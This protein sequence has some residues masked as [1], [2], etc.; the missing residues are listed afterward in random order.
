[1]LYSSIYNIFALLGLNA[2]FTHSLNFKYRFQ[3]NLYTIVI[4]VITLIC[5]HY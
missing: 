2:P 4:Y 5:T 3:P 1:M